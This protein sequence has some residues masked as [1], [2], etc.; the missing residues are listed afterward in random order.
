MSTCFVLEEGGPPEREELVEEV[1]KS[2]RVEKDANMDLEE[3]KQKKKVQ[4][5]N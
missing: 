5:Y 1:K 3:E 2:E 4:V